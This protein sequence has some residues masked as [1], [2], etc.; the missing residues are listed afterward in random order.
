MSYDFIIFRGRRSDRDHELYS[1]NYTSN[2]YKMIY[3]VIP[4]EVMDQMKTEEG[5]PVNQ[6]RAHMLELLVAL[7]TSPDKYIKMEPKNGW[8]DYY[9]FCETLFGVV[10]AMAQHPRAKFRIDA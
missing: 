3:D 1:I 5:M 6:A 9:G 2:I 8:G 10:Q 4:S 7:L